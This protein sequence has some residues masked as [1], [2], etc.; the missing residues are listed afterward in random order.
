MAKRLTEHISSLYVGAANQLQ[1]K[2]R[3]ERIVAYVESYDDI[4]FWRTVLGAYE[5][6]QLRFEVMLPSSRNLARG[7]RYAMGAK[8]GPNMIA[9]VDADLDYLMQGA[10]PQSLEVCESL[11]VV[12]TYA[13]AI[14]NYQCYAPSLHDVCVSATLND[15]M[16][17]D[18]EGFLREFS[19]IVHPL[20]VWLVWC[21]RHGT[22][23]Q[24]SIRQFAQTVAI[25]EV[26]VFQ[27]EQTLGALR[28][29]VNRKVSALQRQF[30]GAK[31]NYKQLRDELHALGCTPEETYL[32]IQ[33]HTLFD[34]VVMP[35]LTPV[36]TALRRER[37]KDIYQSS[38]HEVQKQNELA[39]YRNALLSVEMTLRKNTAFDACP[40]MRLVRE[41]VEKFLKG[42]VKSEEPE[43][44]A[45]LLASLRVMKP[46]T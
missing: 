37:E 45:H 11:Y 6:R 46:E 25:N 15:R 22:H 43:R 8:L 38:C 17:V 26:N 28:A 21:H 40:T 42:R 39:C 14:E 20:M 35:L 31:S 4:L 1:P 18:L 19:C 16:L 29:R 12:H 41:R 36:C 13:Y 2:G 32:Y 44:D 23:N 7:K 33:G 5:T 10:T 9:C 3:A 27:P 24:F 34:E 30:P